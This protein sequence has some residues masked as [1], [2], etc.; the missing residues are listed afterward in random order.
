MDTNKAVFLDQDGV[1][2]QDPPHHAHRID[3]IALIDGSGSAIKVLNEENF[4]VIIGKAQHFVP[5]KKLI[6]WVPSN[7]Q[8]RFSK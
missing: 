8:L 1:I 5:P 3:Q 2:T 4:K 7:G 6:K